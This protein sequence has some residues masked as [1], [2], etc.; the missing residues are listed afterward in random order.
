[1]RTVFLALG[2]FITSTLPALAASSHNTYTHHTAF[3]VPEQSYQLA[4]T[5]FL[6][7]WQAGLVS[8][9]DTAPAGSGDPSL[10]D[11]ACLTTYNLFSACVAPQTI[12][13]TYNF[14]K[15]TCYDCVCPSSY[16]YT[17]SNC[18][19]GYTLAGGSCNGKYLRCDAKACPSGYTAGKTCASGYDR[20]VN[21]KSGSQDCARCV[22]KG[23][24]SGYSAGLSNCNG[25]SYPEGWTY[26]SNGYAGNSICGK[27]TAKSCASG[28][29]AGLANCN[30]QS[31][32]SGW[33]YASNGYA[34]NSICGKCTAKSCPAGYTAGVT[35]CSNTTSWT[36]GS[37]GYAGNSICGKCTSKDCASGYTAGLA[38]C[39]GKAH[40]AGWSYTAGTPSGNTVCGRCTAKSCTA[41]STSCNSST[42]NATANGYY[43]GDSV[44]YT[45]TAKSCEQMGQKT[46]NGSCIATSECCGG[47]SAGQECKNGT[48]V[49]TM[50]ACEKYIRSV[51]TAA[52]K[53]SV[54]GDTFSSAVEKIVLVDKDMDLG[55]LTFG[56]PASVNPASVTLSSAAE[57]ASNVNCAE[58]ALSHV[59]GITPI[60][61]N[62]GEVHFSYLEMNGV[63]FASSSTGFI[64]DHSVVNN[65]TFI[66]SDQAMYSKLAVL[67]EESSR[68]SGDIDVIDGGTVAFIVNP[69]YVPVDVN[70]IHFKNDGALLFGMRTP[71]SSYPSNSNPNVRIGEVSFDA[72]VATSYRSAMLSW[73]GVNVDIINLSF[74]NYNTVTIE[75]HLDQRN[76][77]FHVGN[78]LTR[79]SEFFKTLKYSS[80][81]YFGFLRKST[82]NNIILEFANLRL[83][84]EDKFT[85]KML[86]VSNSE[87]TFNNGDAVSILGSVNID[88]NRGVFISSGGIYS[89][90]AFSQY[91]Y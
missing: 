2:L 39:N 75:E 55:S 64:F 87:F 85:L 19:N 46:C 69:E 53:C 78:L 32:P 84:S 10:S 66:N 86:D 58:K 89:G 60:V 4:A 81:L 16:Q 7:D 5:W 28:Y 15:L 37:N 29:T 1:M 47:C 45:C 44:C 27:C 3:A 20:E 11:S 21:G 80:L 35:Q 91:V 42:Q 31:Q 57:Y 74:N 72:D 12:K 43:A 51:C 33:T 67:F 88:S 13:K 38:N 23:C 71:D 77:Y 52:N 26:S 56:A 40:P 50:S 62:I 36:Y 61:L 17:S 65:P 22:A 34:G 14:G 8:R 30:N 83:D 54:N 6:P 70:R 76:C 24:P 73:K 18:S 48:C 49:S 41:G 63:T 90:S 79:N 82:I 68:V 25:Q 9:T 59:S